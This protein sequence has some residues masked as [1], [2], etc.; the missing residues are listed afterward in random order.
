MRARRSSMAF[1]RIRKRRPKT[2]L[3][4]HPNHCDAQARHIRV[5]NFG[6]FFQR[7][8]TQNLTRA[9]VTR[10]DIKRIGSGNWL[11]QRIIH[12]QNIGCRPACAQWRI[13]SRPCGAYR[14]SV[15]RPDQNKSPPMGLR[16]SSRIWMV[17][18]LCGRDN[19]RPSRRYL[20]AKAVK[21]DRKSAPE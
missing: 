2:S 11:A 8:A 7:I 12:C 6:Q 5:I 10:A 1:S 16:T 17:G 14:P 18:L 15:S 9:I 13:K 4:C 20:C 21:S 3:S 19:T